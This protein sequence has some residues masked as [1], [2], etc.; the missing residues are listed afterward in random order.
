MCN[1]PLKPIQIAEAAGLIS[2]GKLLSYATGRCSDTL[3]YAVIIPSS[4]TKILPYSKQIL[5]V[6]FLSWRSLRARVTVS[7]Q[8]DLQHLLKMNVLCGPKMSSG[9]FSV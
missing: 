6:C 5:A 2:R 7:M 3:H 1:K 4:G 9:C 8:L